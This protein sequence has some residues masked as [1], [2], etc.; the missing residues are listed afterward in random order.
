MNELQMWVAPLVSYPFGDKVSPLVFWH[1]QQITV[2]VTARDEIPGEI[3]DFANIVHGLN[4]VLDLS[5][6]EHGIFNIFWHP[7]DTDLMGFNRNRLI[8][9]NLAHYTKRRLTSMPF[10]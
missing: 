7:E 1:Q 5:N 3:T 2:V 6:N 10:I 8:F 9:L 4:G